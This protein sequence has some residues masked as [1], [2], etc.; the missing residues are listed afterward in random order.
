MFI[1]DLKSQITQINNTFKKLSNNTKEYQRNY[2][3]S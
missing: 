2:N 3:Q 1:K